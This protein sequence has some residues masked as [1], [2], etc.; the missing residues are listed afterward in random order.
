M[1]TLTTK[2]S[3]ALFKRGES[4]TVEFKKVFDRETIEA[5][6]AF[7]NTRGGRVFVG[8]SDTGQVLGVD[9]GKELIQNWIN[10][11]SRIRNRRI[12]DMFK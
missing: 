10:Q 1:Q 5:L 6:S 7:A 2:L 4:E 8:V 11:V 9:F 12:A 3:Q